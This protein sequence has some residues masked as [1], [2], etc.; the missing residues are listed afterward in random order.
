[1]SQVP[2]YQESEKGVE[3][4]FIVKRGDFKN[5]TNVYSCVTNGAIC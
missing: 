2:R 4:M 3:S 5:C 1:M